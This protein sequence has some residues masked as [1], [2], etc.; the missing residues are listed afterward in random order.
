MS[1]V[2][3]RSSTELTRAKCFVVPPDSNMEKLRKNDAVLA[4]VE[5]EL[6]Y[7]NDTI[8]VFFLAANKK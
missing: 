1:F 5:T 8:M 2:S 4:A 7:K 3:Q 6:S